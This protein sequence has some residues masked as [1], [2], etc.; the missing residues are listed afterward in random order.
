MCLCGQKKREKGI[1]KLGALLHVA[2]HMLLARAQFIR[3]APRSGV[4]AFHV[5]A[6][7]RRSPWLV[8][9][10]RFGHDSKRLRRHEISAQLS[11]QSVYP[12][13]HRCCLEQIFVSVFV[14]VLVILRLE[15]FVRGLRSNAC[16]ESSYVF[17]REQPSAHSEPFGQEELSFHSRW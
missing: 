4:H 5:S 3:R 17:R 10:A 13:A 14:T 6:R 1:A 8:L 11:R 16:R 2:D 12:P 7:R 15:R 9:G